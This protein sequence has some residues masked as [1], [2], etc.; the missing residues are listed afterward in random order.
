MKVNVFIIDCLM[1]KGYGKSVLLMTVS[2]LSFALMSLMVRM[3]GDLPLF[4]KVF[5]RN[6]ISLIIVII[7]ILKNGDSFWGKKE[8]R[9]YLIL[10]SLG[11][12]VGVMLYF[13]CI[14]DMN[15]SDGTM[16]NKISPFFVIL[17]A[18]LFLKEKLNK[19][20]IIAAIIAFF[21]SLLIIKPQFDMVVLPAVMG[22]G[23]AIFAGFA[24][25]I[26]RLLNIRGESSATIVFYFSLISF[27][28][29][30]PGAVATFEL[31]TTIQWV[32]LIGIGVFAGIG[33]IFMTESYRYSRAS[34]IAPYKYFHV[35]FTAIIGIIFLGEFP[36][37]MS[38]AGSVIIIGAF[39]YLYGMNRRGETL[40]R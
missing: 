9:K 3:A 34:D 12:L 33:Q 25:A 35:L 15:L 32:Y 30:L 22:F 37:V 14:V 11:G 17:F 2:S 26:I 29:T 4:E 8:N 21:A 27:I 6:L 5:F 19:H 39:V 1:D 38:L 28:V 24:Y 31:P 16:L 18:A 10:R 20:Q 40:K 23:S 13:Y 7:I 36:D